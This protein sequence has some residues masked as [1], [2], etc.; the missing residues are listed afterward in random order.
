MAN[1]QIIRETVTSAAEG[2]KQALH[3][4]ESELTRGSSL[5]A[6]YQVVR[7]AV[8]EFLAKLCAT[9]LWGLANRQPSVLMWDIVGSQLARGWLLER[10]RN[11]PRG[12]AGDYELLGRMYEQRLSE[13][14]VGQLLDR[15]FQDDAAP[16]A[17]R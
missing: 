15:Y 13:D 8:S 5:E 10:A 3:E 6:A 4:V 12:Y 16:A 9:G 17:V 7:A 11:K 1:E 2:L 14:R